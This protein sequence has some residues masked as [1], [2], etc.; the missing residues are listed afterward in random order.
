MVWGAVRENF[1]I[2]QN[3]QIGL[4]KFFCGISKTG[5]V[6][7]FNCGTMLAFGSQQ[8]CELMEIVS[9]FERS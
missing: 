9:K 7:K 4:K 6:I 8:F 3:W 5:V 2:M 1:S